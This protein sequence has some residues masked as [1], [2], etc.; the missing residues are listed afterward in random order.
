MTEACAARRLAI[1]V[2]GGADK[3]AVRLIPAFLAN[4]LPGWATVEVGVC[5]EGAR[6]AGVVLCGCVTWRVGR[7]AA[8]R[9]E[10][11]RDVVRFWR[12]HVGCCRIEEQNMAAGGQKFHTYLAQG[13]PR[14][15]RWFL[16]DEARPLHIGWADACD[17]PK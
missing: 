5:V 10:A 12:A 11:G 6:F 17:C 1:V 9:R 15:A 16:Q 8:V 2:V 3:E 7:L 14:S 4:Y 13:I